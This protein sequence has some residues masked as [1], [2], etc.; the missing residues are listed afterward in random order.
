V[1]TLPPKMVQVLPPFAKLFSKR[2]WQHTQ[3]LLIGTFPQLQAQG[4]SVLPCV[5]WV[6]IR[7]PQKEF[8]TQ[9]LPCTDLE[10][11]RRRSSVG[12]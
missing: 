4:P 8:K 1:R 3:V 12:L 10:A 2:I 9:A 5:R 11:F 6:L 7:D